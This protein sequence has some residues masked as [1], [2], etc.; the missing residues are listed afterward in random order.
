MDWRWEH[1]LHSGQTPLFLLSTNAKPIRCQ[2]GSIWKCRQPVRGTLQT[3][4]IFSQTAADQT[5]ANKS[6]WV[7]IV[8]K[9]CSLCNIFYPPA[10]S[11]NFH[12]SRDKTETYVFCIDV[13]GGQGPKM[14]VH[15]LIL[16]SVHRHWT[17]VIFHGPI[18]GP[19]PIFL[20]S[21][22]RKWNDWI[23]TV[24]DKT[25]PGPT[26]LQYSIFQPR[27]IVDAPI[28]CMNCYRKL[29]FTQDLDNSLIH[30]DTLSD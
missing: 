1:A 8:P 18:T 3:I 27:L 15:W 22:R 21:W 23:G 26:H 20:E 13:V 7:G 11:R 12:V 28:V 29:N 6:W 9:F 2:N 19:G 5:S 4:F 17:E 30:T 16:R 14:S 10:K 24:T 25:P